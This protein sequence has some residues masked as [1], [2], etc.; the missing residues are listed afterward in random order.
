MH[1]TLC[2]NFLVFAHFVLQSS[3]MKLYFWYLPCKHFPEITHQYILFAP[4]FLH[5][6]HFETSALFC[7]V[8]GILLDIGHVIWD[9]PSHSNSVIFPTHWKSCLLCETIFNEEFYTFTKRGTKSAL[10]LFSATH[11]TFCC[12]ALNQ[13]RLLCQTPKLFLL[14]NSHCGYNRYVYCF[15]IIF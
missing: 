7:V 9:I 13:I 15:T 3:P 11:S 12:W 8:K 4:L 1:L 10:F 14:Q 2:T 5:L 6:K